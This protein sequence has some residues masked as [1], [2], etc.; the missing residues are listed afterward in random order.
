MNALT[1]VLDEQALAAADAADQAL[2]CGEEPGPLCGTPMTVKE[3][4]D[5]AGSATTQGI[6]GTIDVC[7]ESGGVQTRP[8][9]RK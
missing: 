9:V 6:A 1:A 7:D 2:R 4:I 3:N 8:P 5:V